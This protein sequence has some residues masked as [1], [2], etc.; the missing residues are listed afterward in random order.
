M[1]LLECCCVCWIVVVVFVSVVDEFVK[2]LLICL[3][4]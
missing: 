1:C 3:I 2:F 4:D